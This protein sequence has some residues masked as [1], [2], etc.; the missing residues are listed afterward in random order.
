MPKLN[1]L[2]SMC[3]I[4]A[5]EEPLSFC[6]KTPG[7]RFKTTKILSSGNSDFLPNKCDHL[8]AKNLEAC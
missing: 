6:L 2:F 4:L 8:G 5:P 3:K 7:F 1:C